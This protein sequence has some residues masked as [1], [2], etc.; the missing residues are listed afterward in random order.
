M[1]QDPTAV[2][3]PE[4]SSSRRLRMPRF[5][6]FD[7]LAS[8][9]FR[10]LWAGSFFDNMAIWLQLLSLTSL[11]YDLTASAMYA[12]VAGGLRGLP[13][14]FIGPWAGGCRRPD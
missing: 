2:K 9:D 3:T 8:K 10:L 5:H 4:D 12:G 13:T 1:G 6:T 14:L 7:S 11:V